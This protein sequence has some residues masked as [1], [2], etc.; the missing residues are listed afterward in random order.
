MRSQTWTPLPGFFFTTIKEE[1]VASNIPWFQSASWE[2]VSVSSVLQSFIGG[3]GQDVS[4]IVN[5]GTL[6]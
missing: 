5:K 4:C 1:G 6:A 2:A 3:P